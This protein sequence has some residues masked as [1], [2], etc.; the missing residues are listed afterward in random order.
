M[1]REICLDSDIIIELLRNNIEVKN[2]IEEIEGIF[3]TTPIN[4]FEVWYG[5]EKQEGVELFIDKIIVKEITKEIGKNCAEIMST[6]KKEGQLIEFRDVLIASTCIKN[7]LELLT[8]NKKHFD[9][10][11]KFGLKLA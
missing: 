11:K 8:N 4:I 2:R 1:E 3:Y 6:L 9:R 7:N 10:M 5:K